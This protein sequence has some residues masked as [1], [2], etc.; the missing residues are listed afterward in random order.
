ME[1]LNDL[2]GLLGVEIQEVVKEVT[3]YEECVYSGVGLGKDRAFK[4]LYDVFG[5]GV[6]VSEMDIGGY[7]V[8]H[9]WMVVV[10]SH[11]IGICSGKELLGVTALVKEFFRPCLSCCLFEKE[12][13]YVIYSVNFSVGVAR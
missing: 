4:G 11:T 1:E 9:E 12:R 2:L 5:G 8:S 6:L 13:D 10:G 3:C 7:D